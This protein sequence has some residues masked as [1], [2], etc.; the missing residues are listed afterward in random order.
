MFSQKRKPKSHIN[1]MP[2]GNRKYKKIC[3]IRN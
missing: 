2:L 1:Q 3:G